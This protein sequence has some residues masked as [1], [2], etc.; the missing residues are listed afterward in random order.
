MNRRVVSLLVVTL[1][2]LGLVI[3]DNRTRVASESPSVAADR[4]DI[5]PELS[6]ALALVDAAP[7]IRSGYQAGAVPYAEMAAGMSTFFTSSDKPE[8]V[9]EN[10]LRAELPTSVTLDEVLVG[11]PQK[12]GQGVHVVDAKLKLVSKTGQGAMEALVALSEPRR[13][14]VWTSFSLRS[15][16]KAQR[17]EI[18]G[19]VRAVTVRAAE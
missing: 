14:L 19:A 6:Q 16:A 3:A 12:Q 17:V 1:G 13:G 4:G 15:D 11:E 10:A 5:V 18:T 9:V 8:T 7:R 2:L